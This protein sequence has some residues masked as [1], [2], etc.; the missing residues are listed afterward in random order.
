MAYM[1]KQRRELAAFLQDRPDQQLSAKQIA[2]A[3]E[4][5][6]VSLS[7]VYR[8][9][10]YLEQVG[11]VRRLSTGVEHEALYQYMDVKD[12]KNCIHLTCTQ[13]GQSFHMDAR[14]SDQML[15]AVSEADGFQI[16][17][18]KTVVFGLCRDCGENALSQKKK[19]GEE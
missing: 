15:N 3:L 7:A 8:N 12:C 9:L 16:N 1:T 4:D 14:L 10:V 11:V 13:C 2:R 5:K 17:K 19:G 18:A 6:G